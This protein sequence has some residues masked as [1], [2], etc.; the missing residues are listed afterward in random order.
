MK[1]NIF[2]AVGIMLATLIS[3]GDNDSNNPQQNEVDINKV[4]NNLVEDN[5]ISEDEK[6]SILTEY[7]EI[8]ESAKRANANNNA[9]IDITKANKVN[10]FDMFEEIYKDRSLY[11]SKY[12]D[13][14]IV[15]TDLLV[16]NVKTIDVDGRFVKCVI[17]IPCNTAKERVGVNFNADYYESPSIFYKNQILYP[18]YDLVG[19]EPVVIELKNADDFKKL[20]MLEWENN[21]DDNFD[22]NT[23]LRKISIACQI[24]SDDV[25]YDAG[26]KATDDMKAKHIKVTIR[27]AVIIK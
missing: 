17:A 11:L 1:K 14:D 8:K 12:V 27:N 21:A 24:G 19:A 9:D 4:L 2:Y 7:N 26:N 18:F 22:E 5:A 20:K 16:K 25:S 6:K 13:K 10:S 3:C 23:Y 15:L